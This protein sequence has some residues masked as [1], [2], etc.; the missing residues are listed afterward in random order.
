M[1]RVRRFLHVDE[2]IAA[3]AEQIVELVAAAIAE[4]GRFSIALSGGST[5]RPLYAA[6]VEADVDW[7]HVYVFWG[8]ERCVPPDHE[9]S[10]YHMA[11][12]TFLQYV[13]IP[14]ENIYRMQG[15]IDPA[16]AAA[17]YEQQLRIF[18]GKDATPRFDLILLGMGDDGHTASLFPGTAAIHETQRWVVSHY[19]EKLDAWRITLT[20][21]VL[22]A[23]AQVTF[24]VKGASKAVSL[25]RV[26]SGEY[27]PDEFPAQIVRPTRG[28]LLWLVDA[29][30]AVEEMPNWGAFAQQAPDLAAFGQARLTSGPAYL[31][32]VRKDGSPRVHPVTPIIGGGQLFLFMEPT[33]PKGYDLRRDGRY[34]MHCCVADNEG[35]L[36]EFLISGRATFI[37]VDAVRM[38][39]AEASAYDPAERYI[40]FELSVESAFSTVY[41]GD[42]PIRRHWKK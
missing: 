6:L 30:A 7:E 10:N 11:Y 40:L 39:A 36:G 41:E 29:E 42:E 25:K 12:E 35:G 22:N 27:R 34:A 37:E 18:F 20:P 32:T 23:A 17:E 13:P 8:D 31:A 38:I 26:L 1:S 19:I 28:D 5:P 33:S 15:D 2:M 16:Q 24:L 3:A 21:V 9:D 4:Q 14:P